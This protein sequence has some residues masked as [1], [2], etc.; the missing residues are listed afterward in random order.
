MVA[1][2]AFEFCVQ[3]HHLLEVAGAQGRH[4]VVPQAAIANGFAGQV[5]VSLDGDR[6]ADHEYQGQ[7]VQ[8]HPAVLEE[9]DDRI[10]EIH[11][12]APR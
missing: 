2:D 11:L 8:E 7:R 10:H 6:Y 1:I 5:H 12:R 4:Q 3:A 9:I